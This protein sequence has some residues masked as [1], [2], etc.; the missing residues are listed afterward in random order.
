MHS[1]HGYI[2]EVTAVCNLANMFDVYKCY[3][4]YNSLTVSMRGFFNN[5]LQE[6]NLV[7][8]VNTRLYIIMLTVL[9]L[10]YITTTL[11]LK[12]NLHSF[13]NR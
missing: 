9:Y 4:V 3:S 10:L 1:I 7:Y 11:Y 6:K 13:I 5:T 2:V 12:Y 8:F